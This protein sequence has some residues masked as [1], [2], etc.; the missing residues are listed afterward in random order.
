MIYYSLAK[1]FCDKIQ[2]DNSFFSELVNNFLF[3]FND[4]PSESEIISW[5]N[6]LKALAKILN[7]EAFQN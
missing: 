5:K 7:E 6:S 1:N 3:N 2:K 4:F